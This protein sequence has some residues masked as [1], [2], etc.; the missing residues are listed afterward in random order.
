MKFNYEVLLTIFLLFFVS[1]GLEIKAQI[2]IS[3]DGLYYD[4]K[5]RLFT[6][7]YTE[8]YPD[9][10]VKIQMSV[11]KGTKN[12]LMRIFY[13][14]GSVNEL[15]MYKDDMMHGTWETWNDKGIKIAEAN[16]A[17]DTK[18]GKWYIWDDNGIMRYD[19]TYFDG[20]KAGTWYMW[21]EKGELIATK[22]FPLNV[23]SKEE[24]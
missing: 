15:R 12:G 19:M 23:N 24:K 9:G 4:E 13:Q 22:E 7:V 14:D 1:L 11:S 2:T 5:E 20:N 10:A 6:G 18:N 3:E 17:S 8:E 16:Y 21:N